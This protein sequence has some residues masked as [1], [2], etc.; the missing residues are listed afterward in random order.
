MAPTDKFVT[1]WMG[2]W[3][4]PLDSIQ[5]SL[6]TLQLVFLAKA[7]LPLLVQKVNF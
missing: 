6:K 2:E 7:A 1:F 5:Q 4:L 3:C